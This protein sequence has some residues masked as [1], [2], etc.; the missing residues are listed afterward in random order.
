VTVDIHDVRRVYLVDEI[1]YVCQEMGIIQ[2]VTAEIV[3]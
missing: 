1:H 3:N 2:Y